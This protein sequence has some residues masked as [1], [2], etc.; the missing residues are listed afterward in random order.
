[1]VGDDEEAR[2]MAA[3]ILD[4]AGYEVSV[5]KD[6]YEAVE[7]LKADPDFRLVIF[8]LTI[9]GM[10]GR[11]VLDRIRGS[12]DMAAIPLLISTAFGGDEVET[13]LLEAGA[14]DFIEKSGDLKRY[15]ARVKAVLRRAVMQG[16]RHTPGSTSRAFLGSGTACLP[17]V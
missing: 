11:K 17:P 6:E 1:V 14:D 10:D 3:S 7:R 9:P 13:E 2:L 12:E 5:G 4:T 8:G 16:F 15:L